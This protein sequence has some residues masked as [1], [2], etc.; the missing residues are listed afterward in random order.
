[1]KK[2][3]DTIQSFVEDIHKESAKRTIIDMGY[4]TEDD[5]IGS[6]VL[7]PFHKEKTPSMQ[8]TDRF[9]KCYGCDAKGSLIQFVQFSD[10]LTFV[11]S[12]LKLAKHFNTSIKDKDISSY[13]KKQNE[14]TKEWEYYVSEFNK[15]MSNK[16]SKSKKMKDAGKRYFPQSVGYDPKIDYIVLPFTSKTG[17]ILGF[18]KRIVDDS[19]ISTMNPKWRH[20]NM[21]YTLISSCHNVYNLGR[22]YKHI[23]ES[24]SVNFVEGPGDVS[25]M[26]RAGFRNT[27]AICGVSNFSDKI[28][29]LLSPL[30][31]INFWLDNDKAGINA[32]IRSI[33]T[34][35][36]IN[37]VLCFDSNV[38]P[39][40]EGEDPGKLGK[41]D[42]KDCYKNRQNSI[43]W[44]MNHASNDDIRK[45]YSSC[46]SLIIRPKIVNI[47]AKARNFSPL[48]AR[49]WLSINLVESNKNEDYYQRLLA[50]VGE[51]EDINIEPLNISE[52]QAKKILKFRYK[53]V[54]S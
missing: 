4:L 35:M 54:I 33:L 51:C 1:M 31:H 7:C 45:L 34:L 15:I 21:R 38:V 28:V 23:Q 25:S 16:D 2:S 26:E 48:Q 49:E 24:K 52:T 46:E 47:F 27:V 40:P 29:T 11:E 39:L 19:K 30:K 12:I 3:Y 36:E 32:T 37:P 18:T 42:L 17:G 22:A 10:N 5:F 20:S 44:M 9:F 43:C 53:K 13:M 6:K 14:L 8:I 50:T 41:E